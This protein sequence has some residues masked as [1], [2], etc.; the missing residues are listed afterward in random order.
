MPLDPRLRLVLAIMDRHDDDSMTM[1]ARR[2]EETIQA[3][4]LGW[5]VMRSAPEVAIREVMV[6]V[7]GGAIRVR[8]YRPAGPHHAGPLPLHVFYHGGGWCVGDLDQRD[9]RAAAIAD[10]AGCVVA[11]VDYR[12]AP[13]NAYPTA[14][15][16]SYAA[17]CWLVDHADELGVDGEVVSVGGESAGG[18]LAAVVALMARDRSGPTLCFQW[19]DVPGTDLSMSQPSIERLGV[20]FGLTKVAMEEFRVHYLRDADPTEPYASPLFAPDVSGLPAAL[21]T[22]AEFDPLRDDGIAY[23]KRLRGAGV[24]VEHH[25]LAGFTHPAFAFTRLLAR[26]RRHERTAIASLRRAQDPVSRAAVAR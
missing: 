25:D 11:S 21:I 6:P 15:E 13:E 23:V 8:L 20:G 3:R 10:G 9:P 22:T 24:P 14:V 26:A 17:L 5:L 19:L 1:P 16:D 12:L 2:L 4:R 7:D 18:N